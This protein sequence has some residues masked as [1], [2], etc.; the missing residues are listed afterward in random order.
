[1]SYP[2]I[3][4]SFFVTVNREEHNACITMDLKTFTSASEAH[5]QAD[6]L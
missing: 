1:M 2:T 6:A 4:F 3:E 5:K